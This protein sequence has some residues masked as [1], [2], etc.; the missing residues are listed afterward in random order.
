MLRIR[1]C[2]WK[3]VVWNSPK[4]AFVKEFGRKKAQSKKGPFEE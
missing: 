4:E 1:G 3:L 2:P